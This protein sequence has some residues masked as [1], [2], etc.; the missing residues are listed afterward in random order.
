MTESAALYRIDRARD[1]DVAVVLP[2]FLDYLRFYDVP[3][4]E[5]RAHDFLA[6]RL[7][8][9]ES[10]IFIA[11]EPDAVLGFAQLYPGFSSLDQARQWILEDLFVVPNARKRGVGRALL[12]SAERLARETG[13][14][15]LTL[16]TAVTNRNAQA[17]Y[18]TAG[19]VRDDA[20]FTYARTLHSD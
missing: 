7:T 16:S 3:A 17:L 11:R 18:E 15:R 5:A 14:V 12:D 10:A 2:L 1:E 13:A 9:G 19:W 20:F 4:E 8:R 6:D